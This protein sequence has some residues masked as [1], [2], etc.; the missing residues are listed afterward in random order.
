MFHDGTIYRP[1]TDPRLDLLPRIHLSIEYSSYRMMDDQSSL[2]LGRHLPPATLAV[3]L[4]ASSFG[5]MLHF[6]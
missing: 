5:S 6:D 2:L 3:I 4:A 1:N